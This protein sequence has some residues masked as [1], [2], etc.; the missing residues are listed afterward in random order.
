MFTLWVVCLVEI[1]SGNGTYADLYDQARRVFDYESPLPN[2]V[3]PSSYKARFKYTTLFDY[4]VDAQI[5]LWD[6]FVKNDC[7]LPKHKR[8]LRPEGMFPDLD[9]VVLFCML[10]HIIPKRM[11]EIGSGESTRVAVLAFDELEEAGHTR[12]LHIC[13]EPYRV[14]HVPRTVI[15]LQQEVESVNDDTFLQLQ[16]DDVLFIDSSHVVKPYGDT[17]HELVYILPRLRKGVYV[18]IHDIFLPYDYPSRW[19]RMKGLV[20]TEQWLVALFLYGNDMWEVVWASRIMMMK[21]KNIIRRMR[22]YPVNHPDGGSLWIKKI[23]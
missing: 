8:A 18:H 12:A 6:T 15:I 19:S 5:T 13:I 23:K 11:V 4:N 20:Y 10:K 1:S 16:A 21:H 14:Q 2:P 22:H 9:K 7:V 17:L 3:I